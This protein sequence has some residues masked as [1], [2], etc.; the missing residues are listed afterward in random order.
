MK[1]LIGGSVLIILTAVGVSL[2]FFLVL[3]SVVFSSVLFLWLW[4]LFGNEIFFVWWCM[5]WWCLVNTSFGLFGW[6]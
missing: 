4:C 5:S 1:V 2:I 6:L 3:R